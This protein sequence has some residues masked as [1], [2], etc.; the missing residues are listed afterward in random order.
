MTNHIHALRL[1][2]F[3]ALFSAF[4]N[5]FSGIFSKILLGFSFAPIDIA[6]AKCLL[7]F[8]L[9]SI[10]M[11][12]S[13][14]WKKSNW[15]W[16]HTAKVSLCALFGIGATYIFETIAYQSLAAPVVVLCLMGASTASTLFIGHYWL[17]ERLTLLTFLSLVIIIVGLFFMV[18]QGVKIEN[19]V[20]ALY[21][22]FAG[23]C[24]GMFLL[25]AKRFDLPATMTTMWLL[26]GFGT[27]YLLPL[28][29][30]KAV[31]LFSFDAIIFLIPLAILPTIFGYYF[32]TKALHLA[33]ANTVQF[34]QV[35]EP[36]FSTFLAFFILNELMVVNE[37]VGAG[38]II[39][40]LLLYTY[41]TRR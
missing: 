39:G 16:T 32:T 28:T 27:F 8:T 24:Y 12:L 6:F 21:A 22:I 20:A 41:A 10:W 38:L 37:Y 34:F 2:A 29:S 3:F 11:L 5:S 4:L 19:F 35:S 30:G 23:F 13:R 40:A 15:N 31:H 33:P 18:P 17:K 7:A 25:L 14:A 36:I 1:G 26:L 9:L